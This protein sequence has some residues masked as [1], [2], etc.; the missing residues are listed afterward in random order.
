MLFI[1]GKG[2][3]AEAILR[4]CAE[5][6]H[7]VALFTHEGADIIR[8]ARELGVW[9]S[10]QSVNDLGK[11][12]YKPGAIASIGYLHIIRRPVIARMAGRVINCHAALLPN[13]R[14]RSSVPWAILDGDAVTGITYHWVDEG[15]D[16]GRIILQCTCQIAPDETQASLFDKINRLVVECWPAAIK[17]AFL[18]IPGVAQVG[19]AQYHHAGPPHGGAIDPAWPWEYVERFV[20]AMTYPPLPCA[21][22]NGW[23]VRDMDTYEAM[24][25]AERMELAL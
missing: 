15:I 11:W 16:T 6:K 22:Y 20:R 24:R 10:T 14:G 25:R 19:Q 9:Y 21:T 2:P 4:Q 7:Q 18:D 13:H 8:T 12:P 17:L 1:C 5:Q 3:A 23:E